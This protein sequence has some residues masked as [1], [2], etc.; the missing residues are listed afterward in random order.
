MVGIIPPKIHDILTNI[1]STTTTNN[2]TTL[3]RGQID[4]NASGISYLLHS[5]T[6]RISVW[7]H[8]T[9]TLKEELVPPSRGIC[10]TLAHPEHHNVA[11]ASANNNNVVE[12]SSRCKLDDLLVTCLGPNTS[13]TNHGRGGRGD[14][15]QGRNNSLRYLYAASPTTGVLC[16]WVLD[17]NNNR[18]TTT[19]TADGVQECD[20]SVRLVLKDGEMLTSLTSV[21]GS[22]GSDTWLLASTNLGRLWKVYK[23]S[24]P[25]TLHAKLVKKKMIID[26]SSNRNK[27]EEEEGTGIVRGLYKYFTTPNKME[28]TNTTNNYGGCIED[29]G[30]DN[31][32]CEE[33]ENIVALVPLPSA[34]STDN[35]EGLQQE[36]SGK[37]PPRTQTHNVKYQFQDLLPIQHHLVSFQLVR[38]WY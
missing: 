35:I 22:S 37:S 16:V 33:D 29:D 5:T 25:L 27:V 32:E 6:N 18:D 13:I 20:A 8:S 38:R 24:R 14:H 34:S 7:E 19:S 15:Q 21:G 36:V 17:Y 26:G 3:A 10:V 4:N 12:S 11:S 23:T 9:Q 31:V 1:T 28:R 30:M 2:D